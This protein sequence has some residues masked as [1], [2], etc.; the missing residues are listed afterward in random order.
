VNSEMQE[1][2]FGSGLETLLE[3][4]SR[5]KWLAVSVFLCPFVA[6]LSLAMSLPDLY[7]S[8][9]T[10]LVERPQISET[11]VKSSVTSEL[12]TR[13][14]TIR[15]EIL[16]RT[17]LQGLI[18]RFDLY[19]DLRE[20]ATAEEIL[21]R[22][23]RDIRM[24]LKGAEA[25]GGRG[26]TIAFALSYRGL[27][28]QT[29][30]TVANTLATSF[31]EENLTMRARQATGTADFLRAQLEE[32]KNKLDQ[33]EGR[34]G[35]FKSRHVGELPEQMEANLATMQRLNTELR[36]NKENQMRALE[37]LEREQLTRQLVQGRSSATNGDALVHGDGPEAV[38]A[39][40]SRLNQEL[41]ELRTRFSE[42][43]PDVVRVKAEITALERQLAEMKSDETSAETP[44]SS[45]RPRKLRS[46][47]ERELDALKDEEKALRQS[48]GMYQ[49]RVESAP[50]REQ[51]Y[52][53]LSRDYKT[54]KELYNTLLQRY[55]DAQ[56]SE[57]M[58][59]GQ[60]GDQ[61]R[62]LDPALP[63]E[64]PTAPNRFRLIVLGLILSLGLAGA[65]V[66]L[67][68][69]RD[70]SFHKVEELRA[71]TK[72]P[73][74]ARIPRITTRPEAARQRRLFCV[75]SAAVLVGLVVIAGA[76][77]SVGY[78]NAHL[79]RLLDLRPS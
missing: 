15:Q 46:E 60:K 59:Q 1:R 54:L 31:V 51:E 61:F 5:R 28:P 8:T 41:T 2:S 29:V 34:L 26:A 3:V 19:P 21:D 42:K 43:Y 11:F 6:M 48:I 71:F 58:E 70:T 56:V 32:M 69:H 77:Y 68:E 27:D 35:E 33:E 50:H 52:Q 76:A 38:A 45:L 20:R 16:S 75:G 73:V 40:L 14:Q 37:R 62:I 30:A 63:A 47:A 72:V 49:R 78:E 39:R 22:M 57:S 65:T 67:I 79:V 10:L 64:R 23:R 24:D 53:E 7:R 36:M 25:M 66:G 18:T 13:L 12:E 44:A 74:L 17:R 55:Q 4:W 9:A